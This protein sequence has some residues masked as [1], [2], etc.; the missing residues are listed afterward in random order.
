MAA[1]SFTF[2][3]LCSFVAS[4]LMAAGVVNYVQASGE[5]TFNYLLS[6]TDWPEVD[7]QAGERQSPI[8]IV[9]SRAEKSA[10][11]AL[12]NFGFSYKTTT[13]VTLSNDGHT[14]TLK[15]TDP[16]R[17]V[18][19]FADGLYNFL[20]LHFHAYSEHAINGAFAALE[21][22]FVHQK[23]TDN[24]SLAVVGVLFYLH[25][26][27]KPNPFF[28]KFLDLASPVKE[29]KTLEIETNFVELFMPKGDA[30]LH[31]YRYP[32]SLTTP[33]C[34][35]IVTWHV[36]TTRYY[37]STAQVVRFMNLIAGASGTD[38]TDNRPP[39]PLNGR[40]VVRV[41]VYD[42]KAGRTVKN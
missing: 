14:I 3:V 34:S 6:G 39:T 38:R 21:A 41:K 27:E 30:R 5:A 20:Q 37:I 36:L 8:N 25:K 13:G 10:S 24:N 17:N 15:P 42:N 9:K 33:T 26:D 40:K 31:H 7:C 16:V 18:G 4:T 22:H 29:T 12:K 28:E 19:V 11:K 2:A 32:G 1:L 23:Q 35:E